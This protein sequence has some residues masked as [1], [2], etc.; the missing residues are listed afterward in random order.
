MRMTRK[1]MKE[2]T[3]LKGMRLQYSLN[4]MK[5]KIRDETVEKQ[6][7]RPIRKERRRANRK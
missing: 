5:E 4:E 1:K 2:M 3:T 7:R 6:R